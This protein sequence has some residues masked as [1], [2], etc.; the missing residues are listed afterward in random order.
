MREAVDLCKGLTEV[1]DFGEDL[2]EWERCGFTETARDLWC[3]V[4]IERPTLA[5][6]L[7]DAGIRPYML[8]NGVGNRVQAGDLSVTEVLA[9]LR[10]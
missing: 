10:G 1:R 3:S 4:G 9:E 2:H 7:Q 8:G 5:L 6:S